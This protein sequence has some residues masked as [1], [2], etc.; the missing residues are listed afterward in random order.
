MYHHAWPMNIVFETAQMKDE[1][2]QQQKAKLF[3]EIRMIA[4]PL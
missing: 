1:K 3:R 2:Q 4:R